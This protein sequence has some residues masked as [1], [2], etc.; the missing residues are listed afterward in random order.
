[1]TRTRIVGGSGFRIV[2]DP[3]TRT[4]RPGIVAELEA[5]RLAALEDAALDHAHALALFGM[6]ATPAAPAPQPADDDRAHV[7]VGAHVP[8]LEELELMLDASAERSRARRERARRRQR[9][10]T[11]ASIVAL[12]ASPFALSALANGPF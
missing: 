12:T 1:M 11:T 6:S 9:R 4:M 8:S 2:A 5:E 3:I 10:R 7:I